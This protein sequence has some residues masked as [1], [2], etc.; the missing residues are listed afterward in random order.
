MLWIRNIVGLS[1]ILKNIFLPP[2]IMR[3]CSYLT[4]FSSYSLSV[5][6]SLSLSRRS[7]NSMQHLQ[8]MRENFVV[9]R[10]H[11]AT[12]SFDMV[13]R[14][15]KQYTIRHSRGTVWAWFE[16]GQRQRWRRWRNHVCQEATHI[17]ATT[18]EAP[19]S[20]TGWLPRRFVCHVDSCG[21]AVRGCTLKYFILR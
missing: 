1:T 13:R 21:A 8:T 19:G 17:V 2:P 5:S 20:S 9:R 12:G 15:R 11:Q 10:R 6:L 7:F 14:C 3:C 4:L 16:L 18:E